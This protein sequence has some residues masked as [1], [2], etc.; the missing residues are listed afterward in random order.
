[1]VSRDSLVFNLRTGFRKNNWDVYVELLNLF[2]T[3]ANDIEY[4]YESRLPGEPA[5][6]IAD[7]HFHPLEPRTVRGG[8]TL[9]W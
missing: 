9:W 1:M 6:G 8:V 3:D 2:D 7:T 4:F 5:A